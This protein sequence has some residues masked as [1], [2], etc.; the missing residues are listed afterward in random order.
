MVVYII[1]LVMHG[2]TNI[3]A[4]DISAAGAP[5]YSVVI[6]LSLGHVRLKIYL[7]II[8]HIGTTSTVVNYPEVQPVLPDYRSAV[9]Q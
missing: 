5:L 9:V 6:Y 2:H 3:K 7:N 1:V 4:F 8:F